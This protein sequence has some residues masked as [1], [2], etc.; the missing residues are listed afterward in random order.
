MPKK[1][2]TKSTVFL[3]LDLKRVGILLK[4]AREN[5]RYSYR[6]LSELCDVSATQLLR[7][8][9]GE[10]EYSVAKL[11][12]VCSSLGLTVGDVIEYSMYLPIKSKAPY[13]SVSEL[14]QAAIPTLD[15]E[16]VERAERRVFS[17]TFDL[18]HFL[19]LLLTT[20]FPL[21][22]ASTLRVPKGEPFFEFYER[23]SSFAMMVDTMSNAE[24]VLTLQ[25][26]YQAPLDK[27]AS[28]NLLPAQLISTLAQNDFQVHFPETSVSALVENTFKMA[29]ASP[30][31]PNRRPVR[32]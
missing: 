20:S 23:I 8:E 2:A 18:L 19:T 15:S 27:M 22:C 16:K 3:E 17:F 21:Q 7:I 30:E 29:G 26:L 9:S 5:L 1:R 11:F 13:F 14:V 4:C 25:S 31:L 28:L 10:F 12:R 32:N 6:E 24:R